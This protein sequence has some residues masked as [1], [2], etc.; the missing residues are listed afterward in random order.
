MLFT[1]AQ[2]EITEL[3]KA[4]LAASESIQSTQG[5][6]RTEQVKCVGLT[7]DRDEARQYLVESKAMLERVVEDQRREARH[8]DVEKNRWMDQL[9]AKEEERHRVVSHNSKLELELKDARQKVAELE[10]EN[11]TMKDRHREAQ[12]QLSES[13]AREEQQRKQLHAFHDLLT[14]GLLPVAERASALMARGV[15]SPERYRHVARGGESAAL[16]SFSD[17]TD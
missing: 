14:D 11:R 9:K 6:L 15:P 13:R 17:A 8:F 2:K 3:R 16:S 4:L 10:S 12:S 5:E 1:D 7:R